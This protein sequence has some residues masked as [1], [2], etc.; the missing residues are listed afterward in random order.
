[1]ADQ[2]RVGIVGA[3][4]TPGGSG[5]GANAHVPA[6]QH[7]PDFVLKAVCTAHEETARASAEAFGADLAFHD[8]HTMAAHPEVDLV[9]VCVRVPG[10]RDLVM[11]GL[12]AGKAVFCE[13][14]LGANLA[15]AEEMASL[16]S[17]RGLRTF[18]GLQGR[19]DP[20][21]LYARDLIADGYVGE[22][23]AANLS[24][25][26][27]AQ[28]E[29]GAGRVWQ[30]LR[31]N[32]ANTLTISGGHSIDA[33]C[34]ILGKFA[35]V[36]ARTATR[37]GEWVDTDANERLPVD[38]PDVIG[39]AGVLESG[40]EV[41]VQVV[42]VPYGSNGSRLEVYG[43]EGALIVASPGALSMGP[44]RIVGIKGREAPVDLPVS[45]S[46]VLVPEDMPRGGPR[47][48]GQA[49][50][51]IAEAWHGRRASVPDFNDAVT[52]HRLIDAVERSAQERRAIA[53]R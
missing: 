42:S 24:I 50:A 2:I 30:R 34:V 38:A 9:A 39:F 37:V 44:N 27:A 48:V 22:V 7:L 17:A 14:P 6:L 29:R 33:A 36:A 16:A 26:S 21:V 25:T 40:A 20:A 8:V 3:T 41:T 19:S 10:H 11:A 12:E 13:W 4:V 46:Y 5:W 45:D 28:Y 31:A 1:M 51:G 15:E 23:L 43:R 49:Y 47:N 53:L 35:E 18:V 52:R 32:G